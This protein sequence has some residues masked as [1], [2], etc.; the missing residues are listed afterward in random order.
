MYSSLF[1][2]F[3][4]CSTL[5]DA[6]QEKLKGFQK[7]PKMSNISIEDGYSYHIAPLLNN[8][9]FFLIFT[10]TENKYTHIHTHTQLRDKD[11][12]G[13][14]IHTHN[15]KQMHTIRTLKMSNTFL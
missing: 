11:N 13:I 7:S 2:V 15:C 9:R 5:L 4:Y 10:Y 1:L 8:E 6:Y 14:H 3:V 12:I